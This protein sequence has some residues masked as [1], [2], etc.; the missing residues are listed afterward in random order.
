MELTVKVRLINYLGGD[1]IVYAKG[2]SVNEAVERAKMK[3]EYFA[4]DYE[5][6]EYGVLGGF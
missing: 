2:S 5:I 4:E 1:T 3:W 6:L